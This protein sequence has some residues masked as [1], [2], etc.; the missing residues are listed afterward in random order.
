MQREIERKFLV[1]DKIH[2][3]LNSAQ[4]TIEI[5]QGY[6]SK[7]PLRIVRVRYTE[8]SQ[9]GVFNLIPNRKTAKG[10][11]TIKVKSQYDTSAGVNEF[12]YEIPPEE[13]QLLLIHCFLPVIMKNRYHILHSGK[14]WEVDVFENHKKGLILAEIELE[15][16][17][18]ELVLPEWIAEE[19]TGRPEYSN[20]NM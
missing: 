12:E 15:N 13:A 2:N 17:D 16:I 3:A 14:L 1:N 19:V 11:I 5:R 10:I 4:R 9:F 18:D 20:A 8:D 6:L 7:D